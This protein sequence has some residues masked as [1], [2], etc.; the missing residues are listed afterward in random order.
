M[1]NAGILMDDVDR[2]V[3]NGKAIISGDRSI[4]GSTVQ[5][6]IQSGQ[7]STFYVSR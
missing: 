3:A 6:A 2:L 4:I 7:S 5:K 1:T